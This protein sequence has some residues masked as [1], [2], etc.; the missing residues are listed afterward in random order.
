MRINEKGKETEPIS[1]FTI[2]QVYQIRWGF[3]T[4]DA[5]GA[6]GNSMVVGLCILSKSHTFLD[7]RAMDHRY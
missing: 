1:L 7:C 6:D 3:A 2:H 4:I 5:I